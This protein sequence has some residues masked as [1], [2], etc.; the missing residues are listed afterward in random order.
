MSTQIYKLLARVY[1]TNA[2]ESR[3]NPK[4][5]IRE[6]SASGVFFRFGE[7]GQRLG[8]TKAYLNVILAKHLER[9][10][11]RVCVALGH[12]Q[13]QRQQQQPRITRNWQLLLGC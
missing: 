3:T 6:T 1:G 2:Q 10:A 11:A 4:I 12:L 7:K 13:Q 5:F 8:Q 9:N